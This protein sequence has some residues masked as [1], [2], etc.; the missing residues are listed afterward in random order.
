VLIQVVHVADDGLTTLGRPL[1]ASGTN[2]NQLSLART[3][4][5]IAAEAELLATAEATTIADTSFWSLLMEVNQAITRY[6]HNS[7]DEFL[8]RSVRS[9]TQGGL[10]LDTLRNPNVIAMSKTNQSCKLCGH[11]VSDREALG[12]ILDPGEFL[13]PQLLVE[14]TEGKFGVEKRQF[15]DAERQEIDRI[16][17]KEMGVIFYKPHRWTRAFRLEGRMAQL[18]DDAWL[19]PVLAAISH[20]TSTRSIAEPWPQFMAD[21]TS[22]QLSSV[23]MLYGEMSFH[24]APYFSPARTL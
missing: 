2:G 5:R 6:E 3:P 9:L 15:T 8:Q 17:E 23:S 22:K 14:A 13:A 4:M 24:R 20:H 7:Q 19:M 21:W 18:R 10:F 1:R 16:F 11:Y 12:V